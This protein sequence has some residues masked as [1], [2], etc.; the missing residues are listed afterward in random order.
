MN[1][2]SEFRVAGV[3]GWPVHQSL[4]PRLHGFWLRE[5]GVAGAYVPLAVP[6]TDFSTALAGLRASGFSGVNITL[7]HKQAA[8]ALAHRSD[9]AARAAGAA[10][11]LVFRDGE[12]S[13]QNTD[14]AGLRA[15]LVEDNGP[16]A[17]KGK[18]VVIV[19]AG[20]A[21]RAAVLAC[22][23]LNPAEIHVLNRTARRAEALVHSVSGFA[24]TQVKSGGLEAWIDV[25]P[26]AAL[27]VQATS[28]GMNGAP[29]L[30][31]DLGFLPRDAAVC[32]LVYRPLETP[33]LAE[34]RNLGLRRVDGLGMLMHQAAPAFEAL[35]GVRPQV[36]A[37][38]RADLEQALR[39]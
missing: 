27:F 28:A 29:A 19:G 8:F 31:L 24:A 21:A 10:N 4:S 26:E 3:I 25:A 2:P 15:S 23:A 36:T 16:D 22:D 18:R 9:G 34:A 1:R 5:F 11:L 33:M 37:V 20:G 12:I 35:Y 30:G 32:D 38:L 39:E 6:V 13:A 14:I 17:F 7:P